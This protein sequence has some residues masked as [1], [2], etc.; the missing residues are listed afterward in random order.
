MRWQ[1]GEHCHC[2]KRR[3]PFRGRVIG[4]NYAM[5]R[6]RIRRSE[7]LQGNLREL[8][9][10]FGNWAFAGPS[11]RAFWFYPIL[12]PGNVSAMSPTADSDGLAKSSLIS[13]SH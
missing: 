6:S 13:L 2:R 11:P 5:S 8:S 12:E 3:P 9:D 10:E 4:S 1:A 7:F